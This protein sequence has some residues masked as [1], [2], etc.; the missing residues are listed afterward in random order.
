MINKYLEFD[1]DI[2]LTHK[3]IQ[4][5]WKLKILYIL[6]EGT[7]RFGEIR[8]KVGD[9]Q[10]GYLSKHLKELEKEGIILKKVYSQ[11]PPKTEYSMTDL[12]KKLKVVLD[13]MEGWGKEY[14]DYLTTL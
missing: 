6:G 5:K 1:C 9:I 10:D 14:R 7:L 4:G 13:A 12:G 2:A 8:E 11:I 3:L